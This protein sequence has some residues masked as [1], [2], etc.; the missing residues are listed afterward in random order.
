LLSHR[1]GL[2][3]RTAVLLLRPDAE[4]AS[5]T[6]VVRRSWPE[7]D[8]YLEFHYTVIR[9]WQ[10]PPESL[11][12]GGLGLLPLAPLAAVPEE[13]VEGVIRRME[14]R[15]KAEAAPEEAGNLWAATYVLLGLHY[16]RE[17]TAQLMQKVRAMKE[18]VTYQAIIEEG[19][20]LALQETLLAL[21][22]EQFG[23]PDE[24]TRRTVLAITDLEYL[25]ALA[26]RVLKAPSWE[27]L[28]ATPEPRARSRRRKR[29]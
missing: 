20:T 3:V 9:L 5:L 19:K 25:Q 23:S 27:E 15:M 28:L 7:G 2:P 13:Q 17:F 26:V 29:S 16:S 10:Q 24:A 11:L 14:E 4:R 18:S 6:G 1:H 21:G 8:C 12:T 22:T